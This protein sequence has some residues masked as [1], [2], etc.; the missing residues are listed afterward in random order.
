M[1]SDVR[2]G[3]GSRGN[4]VPFPGS[5]GRAPRRH[6]REKAERKTIIVREY[7]PI[8]FLCTVALVGIGLIMVLSASYYSNMQTGDLFTH[9][10]MQAFGAALGLIGMIFAATFNYKSLSRFAVL[11]YIVAN[12][13]LAITPI[14]GREV[15]GAR[16]WI[17]LGFVSFQPSELAKV[18]VILMLAVY[19]AGN[20][21]RINNI[22]GAAIYAALA[23]L[24]VGL[25]LW[26]R[27]LST[28]IIISA[29]AFVMMF[30]AS[31]YFWRFIG[32]G[33][34]AIGAVV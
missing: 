16:R 12:I 25:V 2:R 33:A 1:N 18:A 3:R 24:P 29:I 19:I 32:A 9:F 8:I 20:K 11:F 14:I 6:T 31:P 17:D 13:L 5:E 21:E 27:N 34:A 15:N 22:K 30:L 7:D 10:R 23:A 4:I 26:G 28:A